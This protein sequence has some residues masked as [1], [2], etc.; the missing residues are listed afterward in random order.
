MKSKLTLNNEGG[1][2]YSIVTE[3]GKVLGV[4]ARVGPLS[5][6]DYRLFGLTFE[7]LESAVEAIRE[8][9]QPFGP[10]PV[11]FACGECIEPRDTAGQ[12]CKKHNSP[13]LVY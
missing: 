9:I 10:S 8:K 2:L 12:K 7:E 1:Y 11:Y 4:V 3:R 6:T 5:S 13:R